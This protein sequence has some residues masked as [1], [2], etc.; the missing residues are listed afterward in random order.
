MKHIFSIL[1]IALFLFSC[2]ENEIEMI[3]LD[4]INE[5][6]VEDFEELY[7]SRFQENFTLS[8]VFNQSIHTDES[9]LRYIWLAKL[10][11]EDVDTLSYERNLD[12]TMTLI[13]SG[14]SSYKI[15]FYAVDKNTEVFGSASTRL[16][17][18][19]PV[20][21]GMLLL[22]ENN[23]EANLDYIR[24]DGH[25]Y[26]NIYKTV[27]V[28][29]L[30]NHPQKVIFAPCGNAQ[31]IPQEIRVLCGDNNL[32]ATMNINSFGRISHMAD[33]FAFIPE[34]VEGQ[35][36]NLSSG[37]YDQFDVSLNGP[38]SS[39]YENYVKGSQSYVKYFIKVGEELYFQNNSDRNAEGNALF[40]YPYTNEM[41]EGEGSLGTY[42][43]SKA[44]IMNGDASIYFDQ[45]NKRY[46]YFGTEFSYA[47]FKYEPVV[48]ALS[49]SEPTDY[50]LISMG[51]GN[52]NKIRGVNYAAIAKHTDGEFEF[53]NFQYDRYRTALDRTVGA[54]MGSSLN[55]TVDTPLEFS[56]FGTGVFFADG[57][58]LMYFDAVSSSFSTIATMSNPITCIEAKA[59]PVRDGNLDTMDKYMLYVATYGGSAGTGSVYGF[60]ID[61]N[62][63][64]A[65]PSTPELSY[66]NVT[67]KVVSIDYKMF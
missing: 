9:N 30:G 11:G 43:L 60:N 2:E 4:T 34:S 35:Q 12:L 8:P 45:L 39:I 64:A 49:V 67:D 61:L 22:T 14:T 53:I 36:V 51:T 58:K 18:E 25:F 41:L 42:N 16:V 57:N 6:V 50:N 46:L 33:L 1:V 38:Y 10:S 47:T 29:S 54:S 37:L 65:T 27:N 52:A 24:Y 44:G 19:S 7:T 17:V 56:N 62:D 20:A 55:L 59:L 66:E 15:E 63:H 26:D 31:F 32:G 5:I 3:E 13:P 23:T 21:H 40:T 28:E 48:K